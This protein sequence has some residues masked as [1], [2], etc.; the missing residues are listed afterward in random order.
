MEWNGSKLKLL[1]LLKLQML[2]E[3]REEMGD[4]N[5]ADGKKFR[6]LQAQAEKEILTA[7]DVICCTCVGAGDPRL[8]SFR[9]RQLLIDEST[10]SMEAECFI[11]IVMGVKQVS[12][13][14]N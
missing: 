10:Q 7:A 1:K 13:L 11:P 3:L 6:A 5:A 14:V 2:M 8:S 12:E 4:L 9:F